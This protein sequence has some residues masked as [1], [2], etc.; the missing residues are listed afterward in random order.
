MQV[1]RSGRNV[2]VVIDRGSRPG[3]CCSPT[4]VEV[5]LVVVLS[6][7]GGC[8][9]RCFPADTVAF[10]QQIHSSQSVTEINTIIHIIVAIYCPEHQ[11]RVLV[12]NREPYQ[13]RTGY[14]KI[15]QQGIRTILYRS[16]PIQ[17]HKNSSHSPQAIE[18]RN[19]AACSK[20]LSLP[21]RYQ[22]R[23]SCLRVSPLQIRDTP[24]HGP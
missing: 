20:M 2:L 22:S 3:C 8:C 14:T 12:V 5:G 9:T 11:E 13:T 16:S 15:H 21:Y 6:L 1:S 23:H 10:G 4:L 18:N 7:R 17:K 19:G 24:G